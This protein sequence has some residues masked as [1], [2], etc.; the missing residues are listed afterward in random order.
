MPDSDVSTLDLLAT[1][2]HTLPAIM[3]QTAVSSTRLNQSVAKHQRKTTKT[4]LKLDIT[5]STLVMAKVELSTLLLSEPALAGLEFKAAR[6]WTKTTE[7]LSTVFYKGFAIPRGK[8][9]CLSF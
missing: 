7:D 2:P 4:T 3:T 5:W 1:T 9:L 8:H 6:V